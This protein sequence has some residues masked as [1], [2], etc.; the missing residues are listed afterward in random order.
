MRLS[1]PLLKY[2]S[3]NE[4]YETLLHELIHGWIWLTK[5]RKE[6][7]IG[8]DGHGPDFIKKMNEINAETGLQLSVYHKFRDEVYKAQEHVWLCDGKCSAVPPFYGRVA[9]A[10]NR[11]PGPNDWWFSD[12]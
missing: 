11:P 10:N 3:N 4:L 5:T 12:H 2:R 7:N 1:H 6:R 9:R 8:R